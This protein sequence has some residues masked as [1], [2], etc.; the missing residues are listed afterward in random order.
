MKIAGFCWITVTDCCI[1]TIRPQ[2]HFVHPFFDKSLFT[3]TLQRTEYSNTPVA[4]KLAT[5]FFF[6]KRKELQSLVVL[7]R[8]Y[9]QQ[10]DAP[11]HNAYLIGGLMNKSLEQM[12]IYNVQYGP[13]YIHFNF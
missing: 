10:D 12:V 7:R 1:T 4:F 11:R 8:V 6:T 9:I 13:G 2:F 5:I 3:N